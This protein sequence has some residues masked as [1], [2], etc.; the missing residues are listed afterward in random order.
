MLS[1]G[2][3]GVPAGH[4]ACVV[5][6]LEMCAAPDLQP[7]PLPE[8]VQFRNVNQPDSV[9]YRD[10]FRRVGGHDWLWVSRLAMP[11]AELNAILHHPDVR[12]IS[13]EKDGV[14]EGLLELDFRNPNGCELTFFGLTRALIGKGIGHA[15]MNHAIET[16]FASGIER[17]VLHTCT[18]D[19]P[20]ALGF[21]RRRGF[22]AVR[23]EIEVFPDPR[24]SGVLPHTAGAR[25]PVLGESLPPKT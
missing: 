9:W 2:L 14:A 7:M 20:E 18:L 8:G 25:W 13:V 1:T 21:Y 19:H 17:L 11:D 15:L 10:V 5:T 4:L 23:Q 16:A 24:L 3:H 12:V 22:T 6:H